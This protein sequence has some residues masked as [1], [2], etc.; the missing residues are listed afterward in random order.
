M[1]IQGLLWQ[2]DAVRETGNGKYVARCP[3]HDDRSP[4]LATKDCGN[5]RALLQ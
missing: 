3:A 2:L 4:S 1:K 5:G